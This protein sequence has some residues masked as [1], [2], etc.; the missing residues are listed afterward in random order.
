MEISNLDYLPS[1]PSNENKFINSSY[2]LY[3]NTN[4]NNQLVNNKIVN[5]E[6]INDS[7]IDLGLQFNFNLEEEVEDRR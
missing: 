3:E 2:Q 6:T 7:D 5:N 1:L 4:M